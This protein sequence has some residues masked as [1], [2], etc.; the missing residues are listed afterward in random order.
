MASAYLLLPILL[1]TIFY[2]KVW[3]CTVVYRDTKVYRLIVAL[4]SILFIATVGMCKTYLYHSHHPDPSLV[5]STIWLVVVSSPSPPSSG[6]M[7]FSFLFPYLSVDLAINIFI[8]LLIVLRLLF[9]R[10][11]ISEAL[12]PGHGAIY[13]SFAIIIVESA[14]IYSICSLFYIIPYALNNPIAYLFVQILAEAQV[15]SHTSHFS[16]NK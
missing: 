13:A 8:S 14:S 7:S 6:W 5:T 1:L 12:G 9:H 15:S 3:R 10:R 2:N 16:P 11:R 4:G